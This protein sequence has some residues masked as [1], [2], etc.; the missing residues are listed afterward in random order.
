MT[1]IRNNDGYTVLAGKVQKLKYKLQQ[2]TK[3]VLHFV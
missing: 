2:Q 3:K 1:L